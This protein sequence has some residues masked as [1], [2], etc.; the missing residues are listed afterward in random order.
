MAELSMLCLSLFFAKGKRLSITG[1]I[2]FAVTGCVLM[3]TFSRGGCVA[4]LFGIC[5]I[6]ANSVKKI[7][8]RQFRFFVALLVIIA[9]Y[10]FCSGV[11]KRFSVGYAVHDRSVLNRLAL[12]QTVPQM[13]ADAP[14]GWGLGN[15]GHAYMEWYQPLSSMERYRTLVNSHFTWLVELSTPFRILYMTGW[16]LILAITWRYAKKK[17]GALSFSQGFL[18]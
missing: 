10:A 14:H 9:G 2:L 3:R 8:K 5:S 7:S 12:W 17:G 6:L 15:A 4:W 11:S 13:I 18:L 1:G 16:I